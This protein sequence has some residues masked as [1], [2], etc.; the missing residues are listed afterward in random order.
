[1]IAAARGAVAEVE[2]R[3]LPH[4]GNLTLVG[5][6][7]GRQHAPDFGP[8]CSSRFGAIRFAWLSLLPKM[9]Q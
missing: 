4:I 9:S 6:R 1:M 5:T 8:R 3:L 7:R 2:E